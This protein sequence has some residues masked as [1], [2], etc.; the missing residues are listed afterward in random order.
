MPRTDTEKIILKL[1]RERDNAKKHLKALIKTW[2]L[3][4][5]SGIKMMKR[6]PMKRERLEANPA[7]APGEGNF[8]SGTIHREKGKQ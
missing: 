7:T 1:E 5:G 8:L 6:E 3:V 2:N 4:V